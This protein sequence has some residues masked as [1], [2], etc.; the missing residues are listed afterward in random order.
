[1]VD[2]FVNVK[3]SFS[4]ELRR[5]PSPPLIKEEASPIVT[6]NTDPSPSPV[7]PSYLRL[8]SA[9]HRRLCS[10]FFPTV[11][12]LIKE[13]VTPI[14]TTNT[15][16]PPSPLFRRTIFASVTPFTVAS[17]LPSFLV[18]AS[19]VAAPKAPS[20]NHTTAIAVQPTLRSSSSSEADLP[21]P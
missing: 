16:R 2:G 1:M 11:P 17:V 5:Q 3:P 10:G 6:T 19:S 20:P 9:V 15:D 21:H 13:E 18:A 12:P 4:T 14:I 8:G 7:P